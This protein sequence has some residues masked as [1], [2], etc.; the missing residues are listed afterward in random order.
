MSWLK[1]NLTR[2]PNDVSFF[3]RWNPEN[4]NIHCTQIADGYLDLFNSFGW[5]ISKVCCKFSFSRTASFLTFTARGKIFRKTWRFGHLF[6]FQVLGCNLEKYITSHWI[7]CFLF[8]S[9]LRGQG[10]FLFWKHTFVRYVWLAH[11][12]HHIIPVVLSF[13]VTESRIPWGQRADNSTVMDQIL[14][15]MN[16]LH[17]ICSVIVWEFFFEFPVR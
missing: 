6:F 4:P 17:F 8:E 11:I 5:S 2:F 3:W 7:C 9:C 1:S 16:L 14:D 10:G 12:L 15:R 13:F